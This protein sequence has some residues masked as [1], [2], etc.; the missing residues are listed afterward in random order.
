MEHLD[1]PG[2]VFISVDVAEMKLL[3]LVANINSIANGI[4]GVK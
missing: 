1:H 3:S 2:E 4:T